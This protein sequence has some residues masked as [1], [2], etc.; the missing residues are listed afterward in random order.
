MTCKRTKFT[1]YFHELAKKKN[2]VKSKV[3]AK[4]EHVFRILKRVFGFDKLRYRASQE[5]SPTVRQL[6]PHQPLSAPQAPG[7]AGGIAHEDRQRVFKPAQTT[8][9]TLAT[10][11]RGANPSPKARSI[12]NI[13]KLAPCAELP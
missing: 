7:R 8:A 3:R 13:V 9:N 4:M 10:W 2:T 12:V 1:N 5:Q 6:C 11:Q